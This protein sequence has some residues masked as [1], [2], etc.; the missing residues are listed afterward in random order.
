MVSPKIDFTVCVLTIRPRLRFLL[1]LLNSLRAINQKFNLNILYSS[2]MQ[3]EEFKKLKKIISSNCEKLNLNRLKI[4]SKKTSIANGWN[5]L[6]KNTKSKYVAFVADDVTISSDLLQIGSDYMKRYP[7]A[8][9]GIKSY[10]NDSNRVDKPKL[11]QASYFKYKDLL[12]GP[13]LAVFVICD[14]HLIRKAGGFG[15]CRRNWGEWI[16]L[17]CRLLNN[18]FPTAYLLSKKI[19]VNHWIKAVN[20]PTRNMGGR[21]EDIIRGIILTAFEYNLLKYPQNKFWNVV[22]NR[23][24]NYAYDKSVSKEQLFFDTLKVFYTLLNEKC[25]STCKGDKRYIPYSPVSLKEWMKLL[26]K[27][28]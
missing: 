22:K 1:R 26:K 11:S 20:S 17:N 16:D 28:N 21:H 24:L 19:Y 3:T 4:L 7:L 10:V 13:V 8:L 18:G 5:I 15:H 9:L 23:Y 6:L 25:L 27:S 2:G 12:L 14:A